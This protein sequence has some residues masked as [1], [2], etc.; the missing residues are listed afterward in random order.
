[1]ESLGLSGEL[2]TPLRVLTSLAIGLLLGLQRERTPSAK[3]GL[4]TFALVAV[5]GTVAGLLGDA[6]DSGWI[7]PAGL[8]LI[9]FA[10]IS[11]YQNEKPEEDSGM[12]TIVALLLCYGLGLMVWYERGQL[13]VAIAIVATLLLQFKTELH[14]VTAKLS[15]RDVTSILQFAVLTF[16]ILPLLPNER[17]GPYSV[18]NPYHVWLM[19]VLVS[20]LSLAGYLALRLVGAGR[21]VL[22]AGLAG[23]LVSS[24]ATTL[25]YSRHAADLPS[26]VPIGSTI[27][28]IANLVVFVRL[29]VIGMVVAPSLTEF[30]LPVLASGILSGLVA[31][32][33]QGRG[34]APA[35]GFEMAA[36]ENPTNLRVAL[37]FGLLYG[38]ILLA[39][40]WTSERAGSAGLYWIAAVSGLAHVDAIALSSFALFNTGQ[41]SARVAVAAVVVAF[42]SATLFKLATLAFVGGRDMVKRCAPA[43]AAALVGVAAG[44]AL[45][46]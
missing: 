9:G 44:L 46:A 29:A 3:A 20:G 4:R 42:L 2:S 30:L 43:L 28:V 16:I 6:A 10:I 40:A 39:S 19:V 25:V 33:L 15:Q 31:L 23:G 34:T 11:A 5:L 21:S 1:V 26:L 12:T 35:S 37:G 7:A 41:V 8:V 22:L 13:A 14:G 24:T 27:V 36:L 45:F 38:L 32:T 17:I 18:L